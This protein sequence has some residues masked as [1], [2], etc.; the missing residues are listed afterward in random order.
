VS[1]F[2]LGNEYRPDEFVTVS[3][4]NPVFIDVIVTFAPETTAPVESVTAPL[5]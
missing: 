3:R 5:I 1:G 2:R 4:V